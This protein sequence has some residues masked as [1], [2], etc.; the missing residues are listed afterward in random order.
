MENPST[1]NYAAL[2]R[3]YTNSVS[4]SVA[5]FVYFSIEA[6]TGATVTIKPLNPINPATDFITLSAG[7]VFTYPPGIQPWDALI[8]EVSGGS[9]QFVTDG[10]IETI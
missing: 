10:K 2:P 8:V 6:L 4:V 5:R 9:Y 3:P 7:G 1:Y